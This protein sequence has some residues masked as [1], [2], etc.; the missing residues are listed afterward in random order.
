MSRAVFDTVVFVRALINPFSRC[1]RLVFVRRGDYR[2]ILSP[3][4]I[5][6]I[7]RVLARPEVRGK[8]RRLTPDL[9]LRFAAIL[10]E[11]DVV[12]AAHIEPI[13]RDP[14]DDKV[15]AAARAGRADY[16]VTEDKDLLTLGEYAG[17][18]IVTPEAFLRLLEEGS[19][20]EPTS[21]PRP[22]H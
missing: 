10:D 22:Q 4:L 8:F 15:L 6:E 18:A 3:P 1:G 21:D 14:N 13:S 19:G 12:E 11:A 2:L 9:M 20:G 7:L 16:L 5:G 17:T